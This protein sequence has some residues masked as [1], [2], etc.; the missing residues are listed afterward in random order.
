ML[1]L[2]R[3]EEQVMQILWDLDGG[4]VKDIVERFEEPKPA[5]T[6]VSTIIRILE[7]K[8]IVGHQAFG[9]TYRYI[10]LIRREDYAAQSA[11]NLIN[12]YFSGSVEE[13]LSFFV[14]EKNLSAKELEKILQQMK[15]L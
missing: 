15:N 7:K 1:E 9:R 14:K 11:D 8:Q 13:L 10:P 12:N 5:Y 6:T 4:F 3:A 2:T